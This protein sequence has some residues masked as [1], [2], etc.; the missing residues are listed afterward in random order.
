MTTICSAPGKIYLF[1]E[2]AVMYGNSAIASAINLRTQVIARKSDSIM[3]SSDLGKTGLDFGIHDYVSNVIEKLGCNVSLDIKSEIPI[4]AGLGSS[5]AVTIATLA[6]INTECNIGYDYDEIADLGYEVEK[7]VQGAASITDTLLSTF[8][9]IFEIPSRKR[10]D[11]LECDIVIGQSVD[12]NKLL[13]IN[14]TN[15][16]I[17]QVSMIKEKYPDVVDAIFQTIDSLTKKGQ[18]PLRKQDYPS[19]GNLM[20][21][22]HGLLEALGVSTSELSSLVYAARDAGAFGAKI[23]GAGG[24]GCMIALT[25]SPKKV[26]TAIKKAGGKA[27]VTYSTSDGILIDKK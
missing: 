19:L 16:L 3:I 4:G 23:T 25:D 13:Q 10:F 1:G 7:K 8:G 17:K 26:A 22:N 14:K 21:I 24:G 5:G 11:T 9:G 18:F 20:N 6:A 2:H 12:T 27:M 15:R